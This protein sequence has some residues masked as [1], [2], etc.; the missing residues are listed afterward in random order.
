MT[1]ILRLHLVTW[2]R[3]EPDRIIIEVHAIEWQ[4]WDEKESAKRTT[5][6]LLLLYRHVAF[7]DWLKQIPRRRQPWWLPYAIGLVQRGDTIIWAVCYNTLAI[8]YYPIYLGKFIVLFFLLIWISR[9][10]FG[11]LKVTQCQQSSL[12]QLTQ[13]LN[14]LAPITLYLMVK[15]RF[16]RFSQ[17]IFTRKYHWQEIP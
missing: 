15:L 14:P 16:N 7:S 13:G 12:L 4:R 17:S 11:Y 8:N 10:H 3:L 6:L 9:W 1:K 5:S 2:N